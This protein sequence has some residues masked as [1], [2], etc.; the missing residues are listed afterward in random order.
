MA[1]FSKKK[2]LALAKGYH[3]KSKNVPT[4][5]IPRVHKSLQKAYIGRK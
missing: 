4:A 1:G 3:G 5:M 2:Y